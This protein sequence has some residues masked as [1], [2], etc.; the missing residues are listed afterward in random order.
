MLGNM[1][2]Q[3]LSEQHK[4][5]PQKQGPRGPPKPQEVF[6]VIEQ[7]RFRGLVLSPALYEAAIAAYTAGLL[8]YKSIRVLGFVRSPCSRW[9]KKKI[10]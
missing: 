9:R 4:Q 8:G 6:N 7:L 3:T 2:L 1:L 10:I 5:S